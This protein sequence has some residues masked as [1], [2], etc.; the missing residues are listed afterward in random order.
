MLELAE[1]NSGDSTQ[2]PC[3]ASW[4]AWRFVGYQPSGDKKGQSPKAVPDRIAT[5]VR[6][7]SLS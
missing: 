3:K 2:V 7:Q 4:R 5:C 1:P 6:A